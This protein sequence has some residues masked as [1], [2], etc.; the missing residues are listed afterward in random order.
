[1]RKWIEITDWN[2]NSEWADYYEV[3]RGED[4]DNLTITFP[5]EQIGRHY[6]R[7]DD[8]HDLGLSLTRMY[9]MVSLRPVEETIHYMKK[10]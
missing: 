10:I 5:L 7:F 6:T 2:E 9:K 1:M 8:L 3:D 4:N